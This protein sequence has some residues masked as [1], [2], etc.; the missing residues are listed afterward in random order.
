MPSRLR[1]ADVSVQSDALQISLC[2]PLIEKSRILRYPLSPPS[3]DPGPEVIKLF[4][5]STQMSMKF[6]MLINLKLLKIVNSFLL[7]IEEHKNF[8][9]NKYENFLLCCVDH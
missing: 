7:N 8:T 5:C 2:C 9:V 6:F 4:S 1:S 3:K